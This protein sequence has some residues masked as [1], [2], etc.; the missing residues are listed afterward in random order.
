MPTHRDQNYTVP[1][2]VTVEWEGWREEKRE[3]EMGGG[4]RKKE[5]LSQGPHSSQWLV[6][7]RTQRFTNRNT[8]SLICHGHNFS[9]TPDTVRAGVA[10][11]VSTDSTTF[12]HMKSK[13][14]GLSQEWCR[15]TWWCGQKL[16]RGRI[17]EASRL[18]SPVSVILGFFWINTPEEEVYITWPS[19]L[20]D[21]SF[22][23][24]ESF[25]VSDNWLRG[26]R[27][28]DTDVD[29]RGHWDSATILGYYRLRLSQCVRNI[30]LWCDNQYLKDTD[31]QTRHATFAR[32]DTLQFSFLTCRYC[33]LAAPCRRIY[34]WRSLGAQTD[35]TDTFDTCSV[36]LLASLQVRF[37]H[38]TPYNMTY[39]PHTLLTTKIRS[40]LFLSN[41]GTNDVIILIHKLERGSNF[42]RRGL[43][44]FKKFQ[45]LVK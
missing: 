14:A 24:S 27:H 19:T 6:L 18:H 32:S 3:K 15:E 29:W 5:W 33:L 41:H 25:K 13:P 23:D 37:P 11:K 38:L 10:Y 2:P 28:I 43:P 35:C 30:R 12:S 8:D 22:K 16:R 36:L 17:V 4:M 44:I 1:E 42:K 9:H 20:H 21:Q 26:R 34:Y 39:T 45:A 40:S 31:R 7:T